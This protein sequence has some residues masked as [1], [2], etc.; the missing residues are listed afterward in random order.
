MLSEYGADTI[1]GLHADPPVVFT[2]EYQCEM[3]S[4]INA[5]LDKLPYIIGEHLWNFADFMTKQGITR[6]LGNRKGI[7]TR[8]RQPK[9]IAHMLRD[10]WTAVGIRD[11]PRPRR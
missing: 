7:F 4:R 10:R 8:Q 2:E 6:V 9:M 11:R 1:P 5:V 3:V